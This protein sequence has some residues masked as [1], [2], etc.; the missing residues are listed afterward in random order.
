[1]FALYSYLTEVHCIVAVCAVNACNCIPRSN[2][3]R[4]ITL[5]RFERTKYGDISSTRPVI[6][7]YIHCE[8]KTLGHFLRPIT[9]EILNR[10]LPNLTQIKVSSF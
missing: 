4:L 10:S 9:I 3:I 7:Y 8:S 6:Y 2:A 5:Y 1:M